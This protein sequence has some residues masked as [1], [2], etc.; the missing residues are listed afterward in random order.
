MV[1]LGALQTEWKLEY[2]EVED[3]AAW[4][5]SG[6]ELTP[7]MREYIVQSLRGELPKKRGVKRS[8]AQVL[9]EAKI[10]S[11][12]EYLKEFEEIGISP[13]PEQFKLFV[14][15]RVFEWLDTVDKL[16]RHRTKNLKKGA[17][18]RAMSTVAEV[19]D[20]SVDSIKS[21]ERNLKRY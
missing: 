6:R 19:H 5:D 21:Y 7:R 14:T 20:I 17:K 9:K 2:Q 4:V 16:A 18:E 11:Q 12:V 10:V 13:S 8:W 3:L 15:N 1:D